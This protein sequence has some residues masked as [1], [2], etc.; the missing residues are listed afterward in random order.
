V[1]DILQIPYV[2]AVI[3]HLGY[4]RYFLV[5]LGVWKLLGAVALVVPRFPRLKEW[6]YAGAVFNYTGAV[7]SHLAVGDGPLVLVY[8]AIQIGLV[9]ASW[10]LRPP[11]RRD[12]GEYRHH[13]FDDRIAGG[14]STLKDDG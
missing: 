3:D 4:P 12:L 9:A 6:S 8:P 1:W 14:S 11:D 2:R 7:A 10:A 13:E 5:I